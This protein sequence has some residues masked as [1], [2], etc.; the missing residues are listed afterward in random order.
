MSGSPSRTDISALRWIDLLFSGPPLGLGWY[1][2]GGHRRLPSRVGVWGDLRL[3][4]VVQRTGHKVG[5]E[6]CQREIFPFLSLAQERAAL[7]GTEGRGLTVQRSYRAISAHVFQDDF[8]TR[9][10]EHSPLS[11]PLLITTV[12]HNDFRFR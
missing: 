9:M 11:F 6:F 8:P 3:L 12:G 2:R 1:L 10:H 4:V 7:K 5:F